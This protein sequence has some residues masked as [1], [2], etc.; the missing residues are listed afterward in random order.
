MKTLRAAIG[1]WGGFVGLPATQWMAE[2]GA[3]CMRT[4]T[5]LILKSR[6]VVPQRLLNEGFIFE[7][8]EWKTAVQHLVQQRRLN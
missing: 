1:G 4:D 7:Y 5:E 6:R 2:V 8:P 3:F